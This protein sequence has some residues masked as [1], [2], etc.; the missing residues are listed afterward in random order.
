MTS[1]SRFHFPLR[2]SERKKFILPN[3]KNFLSLIHDLKTKQDNLDAA[4]KHCG[5]FNVHS[6]C[7][8]VQRHFSDKYVDGHLF[9]PQVRVFFGLSKVKDKNLLV[10]VFK[11]A[12]ILMKQSLLRHLRK[13]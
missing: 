1:K 12:Q 13:F 10:L 8:A 4:K 2:F 7:F 6:R 3:Q 11:F 9:L 5:S